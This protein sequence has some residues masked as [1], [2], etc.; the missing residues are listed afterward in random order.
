VKLSDGKE[1]PARLVGRDQPTDIAVIHIDPKGL[2]LRPLSLGDSDSMEVGDWVVAIGNPFGLE[3][4][5][6]QGIVSGK[7]RT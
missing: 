2:A 3:H 4:T 5:V 1:L 7:G 6:S